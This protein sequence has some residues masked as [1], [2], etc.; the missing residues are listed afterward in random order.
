[1]PA[2][3][4]TL[5]C[6]YMSIVNTSPMHLWSR[7]YMSAFVPSTLQLMHFCLRPYVHACIALDPCMRV[8]V[9]RQHKTYASMVAYVHV[10]IC[11]FDPST[12]ACIHV[13]RHNPLSTITRVST[14]HHRLQSKSSCVYINNL[15]VYAHLQLKSA[16]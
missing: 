1:M 13:N 8:Y 10:R 15:Y 12:N 16:L 4:S 14:C 11:A 2:L 7:M 3:P 6:V 9:N 5:A